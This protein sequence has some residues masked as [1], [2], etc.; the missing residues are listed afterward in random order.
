MIPFECVLAVVLLCVVA[1]VIY[2]SHKFHRHQIDCGFQCQSKWSAINRTDE[3]VNKLE[4]RAEKLD[5]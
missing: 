1:K 4:K 5:K 3:R 2:L